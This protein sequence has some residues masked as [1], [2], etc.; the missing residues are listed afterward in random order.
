M[1]GTS[2]PSGGVVIDPKNLSSPL[3]DSEKK[4]KSNKYAFACAILASMTSILLGYDTGVLSGAAIYIKKDLHF[5]DVQIEIIVGIINIFSLLGSFLAGRTSDWIGRRY[6][7]VLAGGIFFTGAFLMGCATDFTFLIVGR[8]VAGIG[9]G[10]AMM[11]APVYT[12]EV[13]PASSRGFLTSFP[14]VF[15]NA[16]VLLGYVSNF[17]FA[18]LPLWLGWRFMLGI[19]AIPSV[20]LAIGVLYMPESPRWLVMRGQLGE[21]RRVLEKTSESKEEAQQ[22]LDDIKEAAGIPEECNDDIVQ[23]PKRSNDDAVWQEL[24]LHPTPAVRHAAITA[25]GIHFFQMASG[26]DAVVLY[27]PR[28]FEKAGIK[29]DDHKLL[30]TIGVG[31][32]KTIFVLISTFLLDK[33]G[34]RPLMLSSIGGVVVALVIL[35][36]SLIVINHSDHTVHWAVVLA[37]ISVYGFVSVFSSGMGPVAWVYSS[38]VF[39]LRL[40]AQG[41]SIGVAVNRGVSGIIGMTFISM[42][43]ALT[44]GGAFLVFAVVAAIGWVFVFTMFPETQGRNLEEIELLFGDYFGWRKTLRDLKKKEAAEAKNVCIVA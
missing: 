36:G 29:S 10:Y 16:G 18:K 28:I 24:F 40:R 5:S 15:I 33:V 30:A 2:G 26:V 44:I 27:S 23:V 8:F 17:A 21:A 38:E 14:E 1:A 25:I 13:A 12:T 32:C 35:S 20:G 3:F 43:E 41:F 22:R 39:P 9:V 11:I 34:R 31:I 19:G 6:T 37:I 7:M 4:P 42:Y